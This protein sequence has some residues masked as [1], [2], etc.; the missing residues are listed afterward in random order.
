MP[1]PAYPSTIPTVSAVTLRPAP[2]VVAT[3]GDNVVR[4]QRNRTRDPGA[5][6]RA[7]WRFLESDYAVF[8]AW[9]RDTL[10]YGHKRF[11]VLLPSPLGLVQHIAKFTSQYRATLRGYRYR[12]VEADLWVRERLTEEED[13]LFGPVILLRFNGTV[14]TQTFTDE[15]MAGSVWTPNTSEPVLSDTQA[16]ESQSLRLP[17]DTTRIST[18]YSSSVDITTQD[19]TIE[20]QVRP[21][22]GAVDGRDWF[23]ITNASTG[24]TDAWAFYSG[25]VGGAQP[26]KMGFFWKDSL[27]T[28]RSIFSTQNV[29]ASVWQH[30]AATRRG[31]KISLW[32]NGVE[33]ATFE[34]FTGSLLQPT[35]GVLTIGK[36]QANEGTG[37][38]GY[39]DLIRVFRG[40]AVYTA[41]FTPPTFF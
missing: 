10:L 39:Y 17:A 18:P 2:Q 35:N 19:F 15:G 41:T 37:K 6:V 34:G 8:V 25:L 14:G 33:R 28:E 4:D 12:E 5:T 21:D 3:E 7:R 40:E 29:T 22:A 1:P 31:S 23:G 26:N 13:E 30:Y 11:T 36:V 27:G 16:I 38:A 24:F 20:F 32:H 9:W